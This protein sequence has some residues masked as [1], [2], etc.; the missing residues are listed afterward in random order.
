MPYGGA[1]YMKNGNTYVTLAGCQLLNNYASS[2]GGYY[3]DQYNTSKLAPSFQR[4]IDSDER[5]EVTL[6][7]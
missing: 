7:E 1:L 2:G 5:D 6:F 3:L 4:G